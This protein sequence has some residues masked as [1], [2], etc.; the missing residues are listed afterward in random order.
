MCLAGIYRASINGL[1]TYFCHFYDE[2][3][4]QWANAGKSKF[5]DLS[6]VLILGKIFQ[7]TP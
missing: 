2:L 7:Y 1:V 6:Q 4:Q 3:L 5:I